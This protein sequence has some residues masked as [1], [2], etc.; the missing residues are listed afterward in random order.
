MREN[1]KES[2]ESKP[3]IE[4]SDRKD[5]MKLMKIKSQ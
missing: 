3:G 1:M 5:K 2:V 4:S